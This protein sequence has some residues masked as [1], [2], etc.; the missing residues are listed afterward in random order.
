MASDVAD[1]LTAPHRMSDEG[2]V[3][4]VEMPNELR[5]VVG[6]HVHVPAAA[7]SVGAA[8][9]APVVRDAAVTLIEQ[10]RDDV[11]P[12]VRVEGPRV[13]EHEARPVT[14]IGEEEL[15]RSAV[16]ILGT[17]RYWRCAR[18]VSITSQVVASVTLQRPELIPVVIAG[19]D[20]AAATSEWR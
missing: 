9:A 11:M 16:N 17:T 13:C 12:L 6:E 7:M 1:D 8:V 2:H 14:L 5:Q 10:A 15:T 19:F 18:R 20:H 3:F 4:Q